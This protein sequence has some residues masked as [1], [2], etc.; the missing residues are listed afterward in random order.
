VRKHIKYEA[1]L[2][3]D[4]LSVI[5]KITEQTHRGSRFGIDGDEFKTNYD[6]VLCS[7]GGPEALS[8]MIFMRGAERSMDKNPLKFSLERYAQFKSTVLAYNEYFKE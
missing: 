3:P 6:A 5:V 1:K 8:I 7:C 2:T 4:L